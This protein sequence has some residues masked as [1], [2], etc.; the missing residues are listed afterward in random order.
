ML[1]ALGGEAGH[2]GKVLQGLTAGLRGHF[3]LDQGLGEGRTAHLGFDAD[4]GE[5]CRK[6]QDLRFTEPYLV[7]GARQA[8]GHF[9]D[10][11]FGRGIVVAQVDQRGAQVLELCLVHF[12]DV[13]EFR[14]GQSSLIGH[15][16]R[17][18]AQ[19][20]H[21]PGKGHQVIVGD[22]HLSRDGNYFRDIR[23]R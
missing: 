6:A 20:D 12:R 19:V 13:G 3:H 1:E 4:R 5:G 18:V 23:A 17:A 2:L 7:P 9:Q 22:A 11:G 16:V 15:D 8:H 21:G 14:K 10:L